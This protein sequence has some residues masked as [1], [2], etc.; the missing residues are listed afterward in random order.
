MRRREDERVKEGAVESEED[1]I[2]KGATV[3]D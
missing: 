2:A 1:I 3:S